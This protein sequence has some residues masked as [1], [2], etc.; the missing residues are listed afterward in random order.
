[1]VAIFL[2]PDVQV[3]VFEFTQFMPLFNTFATAFPISVPSFVSHAPLN[4]SSIF[5]FNSSD[6]FDI[7]L[8]A[9]FQRFSYPSTALIRASDNLPLTS[10]PE[11]FPLPFLFPLS[12]DDVRLFNLSKPCSC[13]L[14][15]FCLSVAFPIESAALSALSAMSVYP[16]S[17]VPAFIFLL[18]AH[19]IPNKSPICCIRSLIAP[20]IALSHGNTFATIGINNLPSIIPHWEM[21]VLSILNWFAG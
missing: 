13:L 4:K 6:L 20:V 5:F 7:P 1:M 15:S 8:N 11:P 18:L 21:F 12:F 3:D 9:L 10:A 16:E 14:N 2:S 17:S 19:F